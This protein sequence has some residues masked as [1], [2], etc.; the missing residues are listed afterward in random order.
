MMKE[1][2]KFDKLKKKMP[3]L[4]KKYEYYCMECDYEWE[5]NEEYTIQSYCPRCKC[6]DLKCKDSDK[7]E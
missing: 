2:G 1:H 7:D 6:G 3:E 5:S 4:P